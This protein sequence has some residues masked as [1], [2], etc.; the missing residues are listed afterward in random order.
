MG[1]NI[2]G[3]NDKAV[4]PVIET[5]GDRQGNSSG[6]N[7]SASSRTTSQGSTGGQTGRGTDSG[8]GETERGDSGKNPEISLLTEE[9]KKLYE[10]GDDEEKK[11]LI[12]NA[13]KRDRYRKNKEANGQTVKPKKVNKKKTEEKPAIDVT[14]LNLIIGGLSSAVASRP[15]CAHWQLSEAEIN[16][17]TVPLSKMMAESEMFSGVGQYS[18]QIA[19]VM[20]CMTVFMPRIFMTVQINKEVKKVERTG[21]RT[22]TNVTGNDNRRTSPEKKASDTRPDRNDA[23]RSSA[24]GTNNVPNEPF[25]GAP[26]A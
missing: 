10:A 3:N 5:V 19:L 20:A 13:K 1:E 21:Q 12:R 18:N 25:Y 15:N 8:R 22:N 26:L 23:P 14:Q 6:S 17:I 9:E 2:T 16:S 4:R 11:R 7:S 24:G